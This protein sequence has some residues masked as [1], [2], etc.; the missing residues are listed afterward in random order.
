LSLI[1]ST[2]LYTPRP[3]KISNSADLS[4]I[5]ANMKTAMRMMSTKKIEMYGTKRALSLQ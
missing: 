2:F 5:K 3:T 4:N 1:F